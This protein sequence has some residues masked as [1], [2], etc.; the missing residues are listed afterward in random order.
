MASMLDTTAA[1]PYPSLV[2]RGLGAEVISIGGRVAWGHRGH[3]DGFDGSMMYLPQSGLTIVVLANA[4]WANAL[5]ASGTLANVI[6]GVAPTPSPSLSPGP[7][8]ATSG[9]S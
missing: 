5:A 9:P 8:S 3:L 1:L 4:E 7:S 2:P 6:L